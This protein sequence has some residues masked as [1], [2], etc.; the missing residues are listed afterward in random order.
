MDIKDMKCYL[1]VVEEGSINAAA[2]R[3][4]IAQPPL[5]RQMKQL[6]EELGVKLFERGK[7]KVQLT[8]AGRLLRNRAEQFLGQVDN[9]VKEMRQLNAGT[10]GTLSIGTVTSS[11]VTILPGVV[12]AF[13]SSFPSVSFQL[14]EGETNR[15]TELLNRG[16]I[17][18]GIVRFPFDAEIYESIKLPNEPLVAAINKNHNDYLGDHTDCIKLSELAGKPLLIHRK[19]EAMIVEYCQQF[20]FAPEFVCMSDDVMP[21]LVWADADIGIAI[22]PR[23]AIGLIPSTNLTYKTITNPCLETTAAVIWMRNRYLSAA[24]HNF[25]TLFTTMHSKSL[26]VES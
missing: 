2:K 3:L 14:W 4:H 24:A 12:R 7:R 21:I 11:G 19:Y 6:E 25:L 23:A 26:T 16:S 9:T 1:A 15:I 5:S 13:R 10:C 20:G 18:I 22:V 17:E 8:E